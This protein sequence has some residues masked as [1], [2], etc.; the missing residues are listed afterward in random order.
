MGYLSSDF[1][2]RRRTQAAQYL[3]VVAVVP[4]VAVNVVRVLAFINP[5]APIR[6]AFKRIII[7]VRTLNA[8]VESPFQADA[9]RL[10]M[11]QAEMQ[12]EQIEQMEQV[13]EVSQVTNE[14]F[15][16]FGKRRETNGY[17]F[18]L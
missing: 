17:R 5:I 4:V 6:F 10:R 11:T 18:D 15:E 1:K 13:E 7:V 14:L 16:A 9:P 3:L 12:I 2:Q 8:S